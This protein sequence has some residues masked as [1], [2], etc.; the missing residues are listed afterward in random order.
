MEKMIIPL[1]ET[2]LDPDGFIPTT[3]DGQLRSDLIQLMGRKA[4]LCRVW[5]EKPDQSPL[6]PQSGEALP[7]TAPLLKELSQNRTGH[8][9]FYGAQFLK[10]DKLLLSVGRFGAEVMLFHLSPVQ[11]EK[12]AALLAE[13]AEVTEVRTFP[14]PQE[15]LK[16][17]AKRVV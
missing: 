11:A 12:M 15:V 17:W 13:Y 5:R 16:R 4:D 1:I 8:W 3:R 14:M 9:N 2:I 6:L 7:V 10:E